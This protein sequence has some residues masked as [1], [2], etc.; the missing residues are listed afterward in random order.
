MTTEW[1]ND[2]QTDGDREKE[3]AR[4]LY[5]G[6]NFMQAYI[7]MQVVIPVIMNNYESYHFCMCTC[8]SLQLSPSTSISILQESLDGLSE[9]DLPCR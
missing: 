1:L 4:N 8:A 2:R 9:T 5:E 7:C 6:M 3:E